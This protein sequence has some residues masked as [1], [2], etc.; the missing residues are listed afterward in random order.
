MP[1]E[2]LEITSPVKLLKGNPLLDKYEYIKIGSNSEIE[3][4]PSIIHFGGYTLHAEHTQIVR[5]INI[6][7]SS[8]RVQ[9]IV[10]STPQFRINFSKK[11]LIAPGMSE[12]ITIFF[13]PTAFKYHYDCIRVKCEG[14]N[15]VIPIHAYPVANEVFFPKT[16]NF[17]PSAVG[18]FT[19]A[20]VKMECKVPIQF[21]YSL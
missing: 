5:I 18:E 15:L 14:E 10:P 21:E 9:I 19:Q 17:A 7:R 1:T 20:T 12:D 16:L 13:E 8:Q 6:G 4:N 2:D 3:V 11:G